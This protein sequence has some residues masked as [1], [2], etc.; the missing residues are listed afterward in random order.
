MEIKPVKDNRDSMFIEVSAFS[1]VPLK[2]RISTWLFVFIVLLTVEIM[3][4]SK[5]KLLNNV[6]FIAIT[7]I[8]L[9]GLTVLFVRLRENFNRTPFNKLLRFILDNR[10]YEDEVRTSG[11][12]KD[13]YPKQKRVIVS[14]MYFSYKETAEELTVRIW[15]MADNYLERVNKQDDMLSA[16]FK[17]EVHAK[18]ETV[19][20]C[21]YVFK[22]IPDERLDL[23]SGQNYTEGMLIKMTKKIGWVLGQPPHTLI[24]GGTNSG[25]TY[26]ICNLILKYLYMGAQVNIA[27]PKNADLAVIGRMIDVKKYGK[28]TN[29]A[30]SENEIAGLLRKVSEEMDRRYQELF[31]DETAIGKTWRDFPDVKPI[32]FVFEEY[33]AFVSISSQKVVNEVN[34]YLHNLILRGRQAG[35]EVVLIMQRPDASIISGNIRDQFGVRIGL[36]NMSNDGRKMIFGNVDFDYK[37]IT[38]IGG[39]YILIDGQGR[40]VY[41]ETPLIPGGMDYLDELYKAI[42]GDEP[43]TASPF[44]VS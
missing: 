40:P 37:T 33:S 26:L 43:I 19:S 27:D 2:V 4:L 17:K 6:T 30:T 8:S 18:F 38:E 28:K 42:N 5:N 32:I 13:G 14:S 1:K 34:G 36:G 31:Y 7:L 41:F 21:D 39:G 23:R 44:E 16:L 9:V 11:Y 24:V 25:K 3:I 29:T 35:V 12:D 10:L 22:L 20:Y 15:K